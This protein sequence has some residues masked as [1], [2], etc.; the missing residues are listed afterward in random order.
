MATYEPWDNERLDRILQEKGGTVKRIGEVIGVKYKVKAKCLVCGHE[1]E[2]TP[3]TLANA[4]CPECAKE[5]KRGAHRKA[6]YKYAEVKKIIEDSGYKLLST[7]YINNK[8]PLT[9]VDVENGTT[10]T[11]SFRNFLITY[12]KKGEVQK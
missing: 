3:Q 11:T 1:W 9:F 5:A 8:E 6:K 4:G 2:T 12:K 7:E 10:I